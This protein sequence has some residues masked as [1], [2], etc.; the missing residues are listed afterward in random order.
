MTQLPA[1]D[2]PLSDLALAQFVDALAA[3]AP[4]PGAGAAGAVAL[5]LG[6]ACAAKAAGLSERHNDNPLMDQLA[7]ARTRL[8]ALARAA[9]DAAREDGLAFA[10]HLTQPGEASTQRLE[11]CGRRVLDIAAE[12]DEVRMAL[13][14]NT[15]PGLAGDLVACA[16]L[17]NAG[18]RIQ[19]RNLRETADD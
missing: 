6:A 4:A 13:H 9:L 1:P 7:G 18:R 15:S 14:G 5:A 2:T 17:V 11:A 3:S 16:A 12:I 19:Q 10:A 8:T